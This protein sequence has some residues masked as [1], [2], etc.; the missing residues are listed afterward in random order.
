MC[1]ANERRRLSLA[2]LISRLI[3]ALMFIF[4]HQ[5][6]WTVHSKC[7]IMYDNSLLFMLLLQ[8]FLLIMAV[9]LVQV[10]SDKKALVSMIMAN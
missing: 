8:K 2:G 3:P 10:L 9:T 5:L 1:S 7:I 6:P 4:A